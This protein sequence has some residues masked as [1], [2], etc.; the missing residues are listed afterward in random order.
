MVG[1]LFELLLGNVNGVVIES[2]I[3]FQEQI[4]SLGLGNHLTILE[5]MIV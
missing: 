4:E 3:P 1:M 5:K 2:I